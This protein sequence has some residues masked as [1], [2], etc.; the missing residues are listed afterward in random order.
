MSTHTCETSSTGIRERRRVTMPVILFAAGLAG[1]RIVFPERPMDYVGPRALLDSA[2]ALGLLGLILLL[3]GGLG[4]KVLRWLRLSGLTSL[5][6]AVFAV[7][8]GLGTLSYGILML[9]LAG[10]LWPWAILLWLILASLW[11]WRE[12]SEIIARIPACLFSLFNSWRGLG[13]G[14]RTLTLVGAA[15]LALTM[16]QALAPPWDYDGLMYHLQ[17][18]RTFLNSGRIV[19]LPDLWQ[20]NGPS[21]LEMLFSVGLSFQ[22]DTFAKLLHV[23]SGV[24]LVLATFS[25]GQR[26]VGHPGGWTSAAILMGIP[27]VP[28]LAGMAY[29]DLAWALFEVLAMY[30]LLLWLHTRSGAFLIVAGVMSGLSLGSKYLAAASVI[31]SGLWLLTMVRKTGFRNA[32]ASSLQ[33][34][35]PCALIAAPWYLKNWLWAGNPVYPFYVGG[36]G[37]PPDRQAWLMQYLSSFGTGHSLAEW[38]SLPLNLYT[39]ARAYGTVFAGVDMPSL[40][41]PLVL[42]YPVIRR[43]APLDA[44]AAMTAARFV[45]WAVGSQQTRFLLPLYP[46]LSLLTSHVLLAISSQGV[47]HRWRS[48]L[49]S[50]LVGGMLLTSLALLWNWD[51]LTNPLPVVVGQ[52]SKDVFL[53]RVSGGYAAKRFIQHELASDSLVLQIWDGRAYYCDS[54]CLPDPDQS[55]WTQLVMNGQ[56]VDGVTLLLREQGITHLLLNGEDASFMILGHD[57]TGGHG[58]AWRF[59]LEAYAPACTQ[60]VYRDSWTRLFELVCN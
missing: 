47:L 57:P 4:L 37:W 45:F 32:V 15:I 28:L 19:L 16:L 27:I 44:L 5:E 36:T 29:T 54:R 49:I 25:F 50:S 24:M 30:A 21:V 1:M 18:P 2:F 31:V 59:L 23:A 51:T 17:G 48:V 41:F 10:F 46:G 35:I 7:P 9:G 33:F 52:E 26:F 34:G 12:W 6:T 58:Q 22:S 60:E 8:I 42:L 55:K 39:R 43:S 20:A 40:L 56:T 53:S 13:F 38:L 11:T 3:A 14:Y